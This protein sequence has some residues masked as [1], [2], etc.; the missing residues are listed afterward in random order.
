MLHRAVELRPDD[1][2]IVDSL[3]WVHFRLG[4]YEKAVESL[5]RAV[6]LEPGDPV[7]NDHLGDAYWRVGRQREARYQWQRVLT[8]DPEQDVIAEVEQKLRSGLPKP[9]EQPSRT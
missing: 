8:L 3:G 1:G 2:Y 7:I 4:E 5:E 6:V 9:E